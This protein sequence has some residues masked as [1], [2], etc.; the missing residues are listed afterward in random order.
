MRVIDLSGVDIKVVIKDLVVTRGA[1]KREG[2]RVCHND[3]SRGF[4]LVE[5]IPDSRQL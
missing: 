3:S 2:F 5:F 1:N 4:K